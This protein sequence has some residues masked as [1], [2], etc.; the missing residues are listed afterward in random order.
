MSV[1]LKSAGNQLGSSD[2][3]AVN[4]IEPASE[5]SSHH[6]FN[7]QEE[8][9]KASGGRRPGRGR[10]LKDLS[11]FAR[12]LAVLVRTGTPLAQAM[13]AI[14]RQ[15]S[16][17][18]WFNVLDDLCHK[19][20]EG[21]SLSD[22]MLQH[23]DYFDPVCSSLV[24]AGEA[25]GDLDS[26]LSRLSDLTRQQLR[27][28]RSIGGA[29]VY[30]ALLMTIG[31]VVVIVMIGFVLPRFAGLFETLD[32]PLPPSTQVLM[33]ISGIVRE[34]W[35]M[36]LL[37][38]GIVGGSAK[39]ALSTQKGSR[40]LDTALVKLPYIGTFLRN[41]IT[42]RIARLLGVLL[43]SQVRLLE[44]LHLTKQA[45]TNACYNDLL[46]EAEDAVAQGESLSV[47]L[48]RSFLINPSLSEAIKHGEQ[49]GQLGVILLDMAEFMDEENDNVVKTLASILEPV[50]L[51]I[52]GI[53]VGC[54]AI[55]MF[56]PLFDLTSLTQGG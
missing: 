53:V 8:K 17:G 42:A 56:L 50:I 44:A 36:L 6:P 24:A 37:I 30:P 22:A 19:V 54:I 49:S 46:Q 43:G 35:W 12:Q 20:D 51:I 38:A 45:I 47:T 55:S 1:A 40:A 21:T 2:H 15:L 25:S 13:N 29:M 4:T 11:M 33:T 28:R 32:A 31:V 23:K 3:N 26:M 52:L 41:L 5:Q 10:R 18:A 39:F 7:T 14:Q 16:P 34:K 27:I 48:S 9:P